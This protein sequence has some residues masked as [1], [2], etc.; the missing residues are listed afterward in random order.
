MPAEGWMKA[1]QRS[2]PAGQDDG[3]A[4]L[5][6]EV[7]GIESVPESERHGTPRDVALIWFAAFANF[8]S[9]ITGGLLIT[10]GLGV[11]EAIAAVG[12]GAILAAVIH[13]LL[14]VAGPRSGATQVVDART[15][16]G[17]RGGYGGAFFT[18]FLA[19]GWFAV[20]CVIAAQALVQLARLWSIDGVAVQAVVLGLVV[21]ASVLVAIYGHH[22]I[23]V[24]EK[25]GAI[26]FTVFCLILFAVLLPRVHWSLP[27]SVSGADHLAAWVLGT[28][29]IFAL[30][31]SWFSFASDYSRY[32][33]RGV[34][35]LEVTGWISLGTASSMFVF[36]VLG[37]L[38]ASIEPASGGNLLAVISTQ[39]P[40]LVVVPFLLFV[41]AGEIWANYLDVYTAGLAGLALKLP[42][43]RWAAALGCGVLGGMLA[44]IAMFISNFKD[45]YTN[46]LL[47][48]Y[49]WVPSWAAVLI[50]DMF[51]FRRDGAGAGRTKAAVAAWAIGVAGAIP[52]VD[53]TLWQSPLAVHLLH[54]TDV[55]GYVG[56]LLGA[57]AYLV[58]GRR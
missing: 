21:A 54:N 36:G 30:V 6:V 48:T 23:Q 51:V 7:R 28:S 22:T 8:A 43:K 2:S 20:D 16:F 12:V 27:A 5:K 15:T 24:F 57:A 49:V 4:F 47:V 13:G 39:A 1:A 46:F 19:V 31:A 42:L 29:V 56:A 50:V 34:R 3:A 35:A 14:S 45:Q 38:V 18:L 52:F 40:A 32:L 44:F 55:S 17:V 33:P 9:L 37:I 41:A 53:S 11:I 58:L 10:F 25:Y 26:L